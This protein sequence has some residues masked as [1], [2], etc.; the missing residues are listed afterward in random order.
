MQGRS[1]QLAMATTLLVLTPLVPARPA[2]PDQ[3]KAEGWS[4]TYYR[5]APLEERAGGVGGMPERVT[6][7]QEKDGYHLSLKAYRA[8]AFVEVRPGVLESPRLGQI[9][10]GSL[11]FEDRA[12]ASQPVLRVDLCYE[13]FLLFWN[14]AAVAQGPSQGRGEAA[15]DG[16]K[17]I[18]SIRK[19][20]GPTYLIQLYATPVASNFGY[21]IDVCS[22]DGS[23]VLQSL[24]FRN[25]V[26]LE[27]RN[28]RFQSVDVDGDGFAD[29]KVLGGF[30][31]GKAW[32]KVWR[33]DPVRKQFVWSARD[34]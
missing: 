26:Q 17:L 25:G 21:R 28:D 3:P 20:V 12:V 29:L 22:A 6:L 33:Y 31:D 2:V 10:R 32:Y 27:G 1:V 9:Y 5:W 23:R 11:R 30:R 8:E 4:G 19:P 24:P 15:V 34:A 14:S 7:T 16:A 18:T 13:H